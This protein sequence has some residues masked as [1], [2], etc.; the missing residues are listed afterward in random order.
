MID[1][2]VEVKVTGKIFKIASIKSDW[3]RDMNDPLNYIESI[4]KSKI[5]ADIFTFIQKP[6]EITPKY[7]YHFEWENY[8]VIKIKSYDHWWEK[9]TTK[10]NRKRVKKSRNRGIIVKVTG[11]DDKLIKR[12][13][14][15]Y[16]EF[17]IRQGRKFWH[18][19]KDFETVKVENS[20]FIDRSD[21]ICAYF[22]NELIGFIKQVYTAD[23]A[24][25]MQIIS[26]LKFRDKFV[27]NA[28]IAKSVEL[29]AIKNI[30]YLIYSQ[31]TYGKK[32]EDSL[33]VFKSRNG[34][35]KLDLP[36]YLIPLTIKGKIA[37]RLKAYRNMSDIL[38]KTLIIL[39]LKM[40]AKWY[41]LRYKLPSS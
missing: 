23:C 5:N 39:L 4:K 19:G 17:P 41:K 26:K 18:Y 30:S 16:N 1:N 8:A 20:S 2:D 35:K 9:Q 21:F 7:K 25:I 12:I 36:R 24:V 3:Y 40:R 38:P 15:I 32:G 33:T 31:F 28:L 13:V 29:C 22:N 14:D 10:N 37:I 6:P 11:F 27:N 34:F